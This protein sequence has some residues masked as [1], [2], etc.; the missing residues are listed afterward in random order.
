MSS[1]T[2]V[3]VKKLCFSWNIGWKNSAFF[4]CIGI[5]VD[6]KCRKRFWYGLISISELKFFQNNWL[7]FFHQSLNLKVSACFGIFSWKS[8][9]LKRAVEFW[10]IRNAKKR[11]YSGHACIVKLNF[12]LCST[13]FAFSSRGQ[14]MVFFIC[15]GFCGSKFFESWFLYR[16]ENAERP[17]MAKKLLVWTNLDFLL[18]FP[19]NSSAE[20]FYQ[21][22]KWGCLNFE[23]DWCLTI[24]QFFSIGWSL[25]GQKG[26][27]V[28]LISY[29]VDIPTQTS[30]KILAWFS[31]KISLAKSCGK[32]SVCF[33]NWFVVFKSIFFCDPLTNKSQCHCNSYGFLD[34]IFLTS[35]HR[36]IDSTK[37]VCSTS[38]FN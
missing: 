38:V 17:Q 15:G 14:W 29:F 21:A 7:R 35:P 19:K 26:K 33:W 25:D 5:L 3:A 23:G 22:L 31:L 9:S 27:K 28:H 1:S 11:C 13:C 2:R 10:W 30:R 16:N 37:T 34:L 4:F 18:F 24:S 32:N 12:F 36:S 8:L 6:Q 20:F